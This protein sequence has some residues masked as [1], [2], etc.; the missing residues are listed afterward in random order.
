MKNYI[1]FLS[2]DDKKLYEL[3]NI[4]YSIKSAGR[5]DGI[6]IRSDGTIILKKIPQKDLF[7]SFHFSFFYLQTVEQN[8]IIKIYNKNNEIGTIIIDQE[9][10]EAVK[11]IKIPAS[12]ISNNELELKLKNNFSEKICSSVCVGISFS[13]NEPR[14]ELYNSIPIGIQ[15]FT[16]SGAGC[17][18]DL[19]SEFKNIDVDRSAEIHFFQYFSILYQKIM[20]NKIDNNTCLKEFIRAVY[21]FYDKHCLG[22][23]IWSGY[24]EV[25]LKQMQGF[26][27]EI[28]GIKSEMENYIS[29]PDF[30]FPQTINQLKENNNFSFV[31]IDLNEIIYSIDWNSFSRFYELAHIY[32]TEWLGSFKGQQFK[33]LFHLPVRLKCNEAI[34]LFGS[35]T[36]IICIYR[37]PRNQYIENR[38]IHPT[39]FKSPKTFIDFYKSHVATYINTKNKNIL[40]VRFEDLVNNYEKTVKKI[41]EFVGLNKKDHLYPK[42]YFN[43]NLSRRNL[44]LY[45]NY[46]YDKDVQIVAK[47]LKEYCTNNISHN[48]FNFVKIRLFS[49]FAFSSRTKEQL[50]VQKKMLKIANRTNNDQIADKY[51]QHVYGTNVLDIQ[52]FNIFY[53]AIKEKRQNIENNFMKYF[54]I[55]GSI[56]M[57][58]LLIIGLGSNP[59]LSSV[60]QRYSILFFVL[61]IILSLLNKINLNN[62][63]R[64]LNLLE[65]KQGINCKIHEKKQLKTPRFN[66]ESV[67]ANWQYA[68]YILVIITL[69]IITITI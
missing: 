65:Y 15:G 52:K 20:D 41:I 51:Y 64:H 59:K 36:K 47:E 44:Y 22:E 49:N 30:R 62:I 50:S 7:L 29:D 34:S 9:H 53:K 23:E 1:S 4:N 27:A 13:E 17:A 18:W 11:T 63:Q 31:N 60:F 42:M 66:L 39:I 28:T 21:H 6:L 48:Y 61:W 24:N 40:A 68:I 10:K 58:F 33:T 38:I 12:A 37:D 26:F 57:T 67:L 46:L 35:D 54:I 19:L 56:I 32:I 55:F 3:E 8:N 25:F 14:K 69:L 43:P 5:V 45:K 2:E 16:L